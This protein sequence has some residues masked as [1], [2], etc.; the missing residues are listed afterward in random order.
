[1]G[2]FMPRRQIDVKILF[3]DIEMDL[4]SYKGKTGAEFQQEPFKVPDQPCFQFPFAKGLVQGQKIKDIGIFQCS[5]HQLR[6]GCRQT[7]IEI[8]D[9]RSLTFMSI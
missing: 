7:G 8:I 5:F 2:L 4:P 9:R 3:C 6:M 1:M